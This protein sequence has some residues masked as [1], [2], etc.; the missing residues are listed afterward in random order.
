M[1]TRLLK[2][3]KL[4]FLISSAIFFSASSSWAAENIPTKIGKWETSDFVFETKSA[5]KNPFDKNIVAI[6]SNAETGHTYKSPLFYNGENQFVSRV[7]LPE[8]GK[9]NY[10]L[11][12]DIDE[13]NNR[14]GIVQVNDSSSKGTVVIDNDNK[15]SF[16]F[17]NGD[18]YIPRAYELDWLF[19]LDQQDNDLHQT[20]SLIS[21]IK[22]AGFNQVLMN[23][24]AWGRDTNQSTWAIQKVDEK[25]DFNQVKAFPFLGDNTNPDYSALNVD[26]FKKLDEKIKYLDQQGIETHLMIYVWNKGVN[27]PTL[28]SKEEK[29]YFD[30][31]IKRYSGFNNIIWDVSKEALD[32]KH[33]NAQ[34]VNDRIDRIRQIDPRHHLITLHEWIYSQ[35][36]ALADNL[37]YIS[38]QEWAP[39]IS[40]KMK[41]LNEKYPDR[42]VHNIENGCYETTSQKLFT[43]AYNTAET[44]LDRNYQIYFSGSFT[45]HYWQDTSWYKV[46]YEPQKLPTKEQPNMEYQQ[47]FRDFTDAHP[48]NNW[49]P[50]T[51]QWYPLSLVND[52][53]DILMYLPDS[54]DSARGRLTREFKG[55]K[56]QATWLATHTGKKIDAGVTEMTGG[57]NK[58]QEFIGQPA[59]LMLKAIN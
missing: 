54:T 22:N 55:R 58:P 30:Y 35:A 1:N 25:Y 36:P 8:K 7:S 28:D 52:Q 39:N 15:K 17:E 40:Q 23:V 29:R 18:I 50:Y 27:W 14:N 26:Y 12:S 59:I 19:A 53:H 32:Y 13:L 24:Y 11:Q 33:A 43:G 42:P 37:D 6:F 57:A 31:V 2:S 10:T 5:V 21:Y 34:F 47:V 16:R 38:I 9:W 4:R 44:C 41:E 45:N 20:K 48:L 49:R 56:Y 51:F 46:N 3:N